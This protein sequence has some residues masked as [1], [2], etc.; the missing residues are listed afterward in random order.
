MQNKTTTTTLDASR[1]ASIYGLSVATRHAI[2]HGGRAITFKFG[3]RVDITCNAP[4]IYTIQK[5]NR[6]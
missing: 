1:A 6:K 5:Q 4:G 2:N 3:Q